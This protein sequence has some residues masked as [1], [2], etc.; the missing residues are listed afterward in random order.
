MPTI[1]LDKDGS[2][3][4]CADGDTILRGALRAGLGMSYSCNVG[5]CGNCRFELIEGEVEHARSDP[6]AWSERD[7][8]RNRWLGCQ[9]VPKT[10]CW[11]RFR[12]DPSAISLDL[13]EQRE[14]VLVSV[15]P[16][17][18]DISEI[19]LDV[20]GEDAFRPGQYALLSTPEIEGGRPYS[21]SNLSGERGIWRFLIKRMPG[22]ALT[23]YLFDTAEPGDTL[24]FDGPYG[25]AWLRDD[26]NRDLVLLG[27]GSGLS[28]MVSIAR[29]ALAAGLLDRVKLH[30]FYGGRAQP[31]LFDVHTVLG[32]DLADKVS[33]VPALSAPEGGWTGATGLLPDVA[34]AAL[35]DA[36][37]E[38]RLYFAGPAAMAQAVQMMAHEGGVPPDRMHFDEFY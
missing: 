38:A 31:D 37:S 11:I 7:L 23:G 19:V 6:P 32:P 10:D 24:R 1:T 9:A 18:R 22:G 14:A 5:S 25:T 21:M 29:G 27:G 28:P 36:L 13:P 34:R 26:C 33:F 2:K 8:K 20:P 3:F 17:T 35:G 16:V 4:N 15:T 30:F 12:P